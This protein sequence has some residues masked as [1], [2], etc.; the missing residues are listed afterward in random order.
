ME[1]ADRAVE[2]KHSKNNCCQAVLLAFAD[3]L[4]M[5]EEQL[6]QLGAPFGLGMGAMEGTCGALVGAEMVLGLAR[7]DGGQ[8]RRDA[9]EL[10]DRFVERCGAERSARSRPPSG[11]GLPKKYPCCLPQPMPLRKSVCSRDS[12]PSA[13]VSMPRLSAMRMSSVRMTRLFR[14]LESSREKCMSNL[15]RSKSRRCRTSSDE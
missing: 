5:A 11:A 14:E 2:I 8:M 12:T 4:G 6:R 13:S 9:S 10:L 15:M 3:E 7:S 1:R